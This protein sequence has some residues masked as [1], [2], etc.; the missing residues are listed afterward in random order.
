MWQ[1]TG[2]FD[3][4]FENS[5]NI[6]HSVH[7]EAPMACAMALASLVNSVEMSAVSGLHLLDADLLQVTQGYKIPW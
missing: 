7:A 4:F 3:G 1:F 2:N 5:N 6:E